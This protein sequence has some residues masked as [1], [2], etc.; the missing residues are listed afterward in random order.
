MEEDRTRVLGTV[1]YVRYG[2]EDHDIFT[3]SIGIDFNGYHQSFGN[4]FLDAQ[5]K[6]PAFRDAICQLFG[7]DTKN[8]EKE[9]VG[10]QCYGLYNFPYWNDPIEGLESLDGRRFTITKFAR[11]FDE[12][13]SPLQRRKESLNRDIAHIERRILETKLSLKKLDD[14]FTSWE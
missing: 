7:I 3:C 6:G 14:D 9:L 4:I 1:T 10:K 13:A 5:K 12:V 11:Q 2:K 8:W